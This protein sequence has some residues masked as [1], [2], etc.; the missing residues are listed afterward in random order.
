M[1]TYVYKN[2]VCPEFQEESSGETS[3]FNVPIEY[4]DEVQCGYC[5]TPLKRKI[6]FTG[7]TWAP[8]AGGMR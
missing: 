5:Y 3:E 1:P 6:V 8:T 7:S 4:R 2:C